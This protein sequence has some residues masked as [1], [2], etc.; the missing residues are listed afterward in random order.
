MSRSAL[1][2]IAA[3]ALL[4]V[5]GVGVS[6]SLSPEPVPIATPIDLSG[7]APPARPALDGFFVVPPR[8]VD[9]REDDEEEGTA[10]GAP[11]DGSPGATGTSPD[12]SPDDTP[13]IDD[14]PDDSP[15]DTPDIDDSPDDS[16]DDDD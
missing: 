11:S 9:F 4:A 10:V 3:L 14:T 12:D 6:E 16:P 7:E 2:W 15:D 1:A 5:A 13:D 8:V